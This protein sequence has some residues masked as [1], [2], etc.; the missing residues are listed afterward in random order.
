[1]STAYSSPLSM[2]LYAFS[3][4]AHRLSSIERLTREVL[5]QAVVRRPCMR[6]HALEPGKTRGNLPDLARRLGGHTLPS[7]RLDELVHRQSP[8][9]PSCSHR[10]QDV[11]GPRGLVPKGHRSLLAQEERAVGSQVCQPPIEIPGM[12]LEVLRSSFVGQ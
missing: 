8:G 4:A 1:T 12:D 10:G 7:Q 3:L 9:V 2:S 5:R 11:V 6:L